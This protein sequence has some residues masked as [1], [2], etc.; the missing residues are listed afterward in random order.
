MFDPNLDWGRIDPPSR[1]T[2]EEQEAR[3]L[4]EDQEAE[5]RGDRERE[6][7]GE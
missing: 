3:E 6:E 7:A 5:L 1:Y 2:E 4:A